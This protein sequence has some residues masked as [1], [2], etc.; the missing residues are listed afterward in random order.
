MASHQYII[1]M[2]NPHVENQIIK[3]VDFSSG[4]NLSQEY[5]SCTFVNCVFAKASLNAVK[6]IECTFE[7]CDLSVAT[8][9]QTGLQDVKFIECKLLGLQFGDCNHFLF[10]VTFDKCN[11]QLSGFYKLKMKG[12]RIKNCELHEVDFTEAD[13]SDAVFD[14]CDLS[15]AIFDHSNLEKAD[16]RTAYNYTID[17]AANRMK[18]ARFALAGAPGLLANFNIMIE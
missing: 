2:D 14:E 13:L 8:L 16:F 7:K 18:G 5:N 3:D 4:V 12:L 9:K 6:F 10:E 15:R 17:P 11:L 1:I